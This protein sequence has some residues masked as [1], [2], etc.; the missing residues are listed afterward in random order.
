[1]K[2]MSCV[3]MLASLAACGGNPDPQGSS[4][5]VGP[6][7]PQGPM[8]VA[9]STG[10]TGATGPQGPVGEAGSAGA[11][12]PQGP[13]GV[14]GT[15]SDAGLIGPQGPAGSVG[16]QG[17]TGATGAAGSTGATGATGPQGPMGE[18][19]AMGATGPQGPSGDITGSI[20]CVGTVSGGPLSGTYSMGYT[21]DQFSDGAVFSTGYISGASIS[22]S[23]S[24]FFAPQQTGWDTAPVQFTYDVYSGADGGWWL[25]SLDRSTLVVSIT[26]NDTDLGGTDTYTWAWQPSQCTVNTYN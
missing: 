22:V 7:G 26:Y 21:A 1:M 8:G 16:P 17:P 19:G 5:D 11:T 6:V 10:A 24:A 15:T 9:G 25:I 12:G 4:V 2:R 18:A 13:M 14:A 20:G 3:L 23:G